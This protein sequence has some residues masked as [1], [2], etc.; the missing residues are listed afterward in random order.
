MSLRYIAMFFWGF[1]LILMAAASLGF[2]LDAGQ[3]LDAEGKFSPDTRIY[4]GNL[5]CCE[6]QRLS[7]CRHIG[8]CRPR[9]VLSS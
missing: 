8:G 9:G 6:G 1:V 3:Y 5:F 4:A 2:I 7:P